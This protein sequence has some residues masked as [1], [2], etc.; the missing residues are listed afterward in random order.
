MQHLPPV[1]QIQAGPPIASFFDDQFV[2]P[3]LDQLSGTS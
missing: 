1:V 3:V 2:E